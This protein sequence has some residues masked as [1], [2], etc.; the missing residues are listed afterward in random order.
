MGW[1]HLHLH[2]E[3]FEALP[4]FCVFNNQLQFTASEKLNGFTVSVY[5]S[6]N[7]VNGPVNTTRRVTAAD[8]NGCALQVPAMQSFNL[9]LN[10]ASGS[11]IQYESRGI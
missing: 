1:V 8:S 6:V 7:T 4:S 9:V 5:T 3:R 2:H 11:E 10:S